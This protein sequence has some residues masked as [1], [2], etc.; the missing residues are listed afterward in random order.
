ME[1]VINPGLHNITVLLT[2]VDEVAVIPGAGAGSRRDEEYEQF[3]ADVWVGVVL[4]LMVLSCVC[5]VCSCLLYHKFQQWK[6]SVLESRG[7]SMET[8][9]ASGGD[10]ESLPSYT[11]VSGLPT[12]DEAL[13]QLRQVQE[14]QTDNKLAEV[15]AQST[16][17]NAISSDNNRQQHSL[18]KLSVVEFLQQYKSYPQQ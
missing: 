11:I 7:N 2:E 3:L 10:V 8:G 9:G 17:S 13:E 14:L 12:Y 18:S 15:Q 6:R 16:Q 5:C 1:S 4:T